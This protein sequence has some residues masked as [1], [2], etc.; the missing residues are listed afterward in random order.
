MLHFMV[1]LLKSMAF[2]LTLLVKFKKNFLPMYHEEFG[3]IN[4]I[5]FNVRFSNG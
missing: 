2:D 4:E 1:T 5:M 3:Q